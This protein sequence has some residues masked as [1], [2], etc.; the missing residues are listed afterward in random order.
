MCLG[1]PPHHAATVPTDETIDGHTGVGGLAEDL[2]RTRGDLEGVMR[3]EE[4]DTVGTA[5]DLMAILAVAEDLFWFTQWSVGRYVSWWGRE[6]TLA[7][8]SPL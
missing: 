8:G 4:V 7:A 6:L 1:L 5:A 2:G 3:D